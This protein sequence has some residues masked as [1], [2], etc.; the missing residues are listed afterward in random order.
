[1]LCDCGPWWFSEFESTFLSRLSV[2]SMFIQFVHHKGFGLGLGWPA[3]LLVSCTTQGVLIL[4]SHK[5]CLDDLTHLLGF[6]WYIHQ[7]H[8]S[9]GCL[10]VNACIGQHKSICQQE[11]SNM[12]I[13]IKDQGSQ[14]LSIE[15][16]TCQMSFLLVLYKMDGETKICFN[17]L[18]EQIQSI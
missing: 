18:S 3:C 4:A 16:Q 9:I 8:I 13:Y 7:R 14:K 1:M 12:S 6:V 10:Q 15:N 2:L 5:P 11:L 17:F